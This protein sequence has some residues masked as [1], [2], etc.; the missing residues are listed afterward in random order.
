MKFLSKLILVG[1]LLSPVL[2]EALAPVFIGTTTSYISNS[3]DGGTWTLV[4]SNQI[5][6]KWHGA[7]KTL[8]IVE[9][10]Y[11]FGNNPF[12][13]FHQGTFGGLTNTYGL[14][15][16]AISGSASPWSGTGLAMTNGSYRLGAFNSGAGGTIS[17]LAVHVVNTIAATGSIRFGIW[18]I[19]STTNLFPSALVWES[20]DIAL[21][22][23]GS[24]VAT[25]IAVATNIVLKPNRW[26]WQAVQT[27]QNGLQLSIPSGASIVQTVLGGNGGMLS[28][29]NKP[30]ISFDVT[31]TYGAWP[32]TFPALPAIIDGTPGNVN[33]AVILGASFQ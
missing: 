18:S 17:S 1:A 15:Y 26:Y 20:G 23:G 22:A 16:T 21:T 9:G 3:A 7:A 8:Q 6:A 5:V 29:N 30:V 25:N 2:A 11:L 4:V 27:S 31:N 24:S 13:G 19:T 32:A 10:A 12:V 28:D 33:T 14:G